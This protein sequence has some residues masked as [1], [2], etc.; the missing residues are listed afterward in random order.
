MLVRVQIPQKLCLWFGLLIL[1][2]AQKR[3]WD[4][5]G[6]PLAGFRHAFFTLRNGL[7]LHYVVNCA[8]V[9]EAKNVAVFIHGE[10]SG[11]VVSIH[12]Y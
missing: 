9:T 6:E 10:Q 3:Y 7:K 8:E 4:V 2:T 12:L 5:E 11:A 1:A